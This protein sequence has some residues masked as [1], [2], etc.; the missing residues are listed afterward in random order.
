[1]VTVRRRG[2]DAAWFEADCRRAFELK[3]AAYHR[4][5]RNCT[6]VNWN[7]FCQSRS[8]ANRLYAAVKVHC[9]ANYRLMIVPLIMPGGVH[10][11]VMC[12][13]RSPMFFLFILLVVRFF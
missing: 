7:S 4:W 6:A 10:K 9:S 3:Q 8:T 13:V 12:L 5:C 2:G 1:M 11:K